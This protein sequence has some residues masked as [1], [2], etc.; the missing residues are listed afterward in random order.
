MPRSANPSDFTVPV[1]GV[2]E[3]VFG[4]RKMADH[5]KIEVE[6]ARITEGVMPTPWLDK[7]AT[8][9]ATI[10]IL[11]VRVPDTFNMEE[12]D[13]LEEKTYADLSKVFFA[14]REKEDSFR[15]GPQVQGQ[16]GGAAQV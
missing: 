12:M 10:R 16:A 11:A 14:L 2:G 9:Q 15:R 4:R 13:P 5:M 1:E 8:W 3:F 7:L 6:Y